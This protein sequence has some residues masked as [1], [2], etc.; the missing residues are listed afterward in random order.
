MDLNKI[1]ESIADVIDQKP[2]FTMWFVFKD[3]EKIDIRLAN[4]VSTEKKQKSDQMQISKVFIDKLKDMCNTADAM[5]LRKVS[6]LVAEKNSIFEYDYE[7]DESPQIVKIFYDMNI[8]SIDKYQNFNFHKQDI[9]K[10][11]AYVFYLGTMEQGVFLYKQ[12]YPVSLIKRGNRIIRIIDDTRMEFYESDDLI[13]ISSDFHLLKVNNKIY[14]TDISVLEK[15]LGFNEIITNH[16]ERAIEL[17]E[18]IGVLEEI[19]VLREELSNMRIV[20]KLANM[21][22]SSPV[23]QN[24]ISAGELINFSKTNQSLIGR[25]KYSADGKRFLLTTKKSKEDFIK[26]LNDDFL[27]SELT[28]KRYEAIGKDAIENG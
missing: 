8:E 1:M 25:F 11:F 7:Y 12:H 4:I 2:S 17:I 24:H 10:L 18:E 22:E 16:A 23:F 14:V 26:L 5:S 20:R 6:D 3:G 28:G 15:K 21:K 19:D 27:L 13:R 9:S